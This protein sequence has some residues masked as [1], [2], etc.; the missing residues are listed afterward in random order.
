MSHIP[1]RARTRRTEP[2]R[3]RVTK[4]PRPADTN[5]VQFRSYFSGFSDRFHLV[6]QICSRVSPHSG[7]R[8]D[9]YIYSVLTLSPFS[10]I[11]YSK[12]LLEF[13]FYFWATN[14]RLNRGLTRHPELGAGELLRE[15]KPLGEEVILRSGRGT[16]HFSFK[17]VLLHDYVTLSQQFIFILI[18]L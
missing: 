8:K 14:V 11:L 7:T 9:N 3:V 6:L 4:H 16:G 5:T 2:V 18:L 13:S 1:T 15:F 10:T 17:A 12:I